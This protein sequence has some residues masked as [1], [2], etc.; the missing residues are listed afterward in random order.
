MAD[1]NR[2]TDIPGDSTHQGTGDADTFVFGP[3]YTNADTITGFT[4][5]DDRIDL[6]RFAGITRFEDL[7]VTSD[8][9]GVTI[10]LTA[11]GGGTIRLAGFSID[12]LGA[13]DFVFSRLDGGGT[14][15]DD[16]LQA[17]DGGDR[18]D[19]GAGDDFLWGGAGDDILLGGEGDD[20]IRGGA[21]D[22]VL[23]AGAGDDYLYGGTGDDLLYGGAGDDYIQGGAG[24]NVLEGHEGDDDLY[25]R[26]GDD[27]LYGG[28]GNDALVGNGGDDEL[29]GGEGN[30]ALVGGGELYGGGGDDEL[31]G[32][33]ERGDLYGGEGDDVLYGG[34][35]GNT[36]YGGQG[37]DWIAGGRGDDTLH[38]GWGDDTFA[39]TAGD[40][41]DTIADFADGEDAIDLTMFTDITGFGDLTITA[42]GSAAVIDLAGQH[43][44]GTIRLDDT[45]VSDLGAEDFL[46]YEPP[47]EPGADGG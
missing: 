1:E 9:G 33:G 16:E 22:D 2:I 32:G 38:G 30:D 10:D 4:N 20:F 34:P 44:G 37:D 6:T 13:T 36:L 26:G 23:E 8:D 43:R 11:H 19:G 14:T 5:G 39:F 25:G 17:D 21:G 28:E 45:D 40:R 47:A 31:Y 42:D 35:G 15:G 7:T 27:F 3:G 18:L 29:Y 24:D 12:N 41:N 46:F